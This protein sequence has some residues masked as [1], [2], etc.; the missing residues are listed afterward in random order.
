MVL[1]STGDLQITDGNVQAPDTPVG[2]Q[3]GSSVN[4]SVGASTDSPS[5]AKAEPVN[6]VRR[7]GLWRRPHKKHD[8]QFVYRLGQHPK[9]FVLFLCLSTHSCY[10]FRLGQTSF[11]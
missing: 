3:N 10:L 1:Q 9:I 7:Y 4:G 5:T 2:V 6:G 8:P 11:V